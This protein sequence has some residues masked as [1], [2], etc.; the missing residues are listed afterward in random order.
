LDI[1]LEK[2]VF[3]EQSIPLIPTTKGRL[4]ER[5]CSYLVLIN[6]SMSCTIAQMIIY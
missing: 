1:A 4:M 6:A 5:C 3:P 2:V